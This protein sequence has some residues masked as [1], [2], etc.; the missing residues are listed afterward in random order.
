MFSIFGD[1]GIVGM[2]KRTLRNT[3]FF[4]TSFLLNSLALNQN[5]FG[6]LKSFLL[7][8]AVLFVHFVSSAQCLKS[9]STCNIAAIRTALT[10]AGC[11]ELGCGSDSCSIYFFNPATLTADSAERFAVNLGGH[12]ASIQSASQN[13]SIVKWLTVPGHSGA[14]WLGFNDVTTEGKFLWTDGSDTTY[15]NWAI[16]KPN[17][18]TANDDYVNLWISGADSSKWNDTIGSISLK[19]VIKISLCMDLTMSPKDTICKNDSSS[20]YVSPRFGSTPYS[21]LWSTT[22]IADTVKVSPALTSTYKVTVTDRYACTATDS[23][24]LK[25]DTLPTFSMG[26]TDTICGDTFLILDAGAGYKYKWHTGL[27]HQLP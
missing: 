2:N 9:G 10:N 17:A 24:E 26:G 12:L 22:S 15:K 13:D 18:A 20:L 16:G 3:S 19:S 14:V 1:E 6:S 4:D 7:V 11:V 27:S 25:I 21:F 8:F 5:Y 23:I